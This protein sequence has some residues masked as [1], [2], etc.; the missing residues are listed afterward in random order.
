MAQKTCMPL[1]R[2]VMIDPDIEGGYC[3]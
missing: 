3:A 1:Q 2:Q